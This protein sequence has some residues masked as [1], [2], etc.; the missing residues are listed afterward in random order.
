LKMAL[1]T[2]LSKAGSFI[3]LPE[4]SSTWSRYN[5]LA[6]LSSSNS[7]GPAKLQIVERLYSD[8]VEV[9]MWPDTFAVVVRASFL[10]S[11]RQGR[12]L[13][14]RISWR[15]PRR[16]YLCRNTT[17]LWGKC[18][19]RSE[20]DWSRIDLWTTLLTLKF[21]SQRLWKNAL[22]CGMRKRRNLS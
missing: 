17:Y 6:S 10:R 13:I 19:A 22:D 8:T 14:E 21:L 18:R 12:E 11:K 5:Y 1:S 7:H 20:I 15:R 2:S 9:L 4:V 16:K 3:S